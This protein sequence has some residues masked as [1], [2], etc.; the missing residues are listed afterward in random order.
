MCFDIFAIVVFSDIR[1]IKYIIHENNSFL[2][3]HSLINSK[4]INDFY[5]FYDNCKNKYD[6]C[7]NLEKIAF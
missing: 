4:F 6:Y 1:K 7:I 2:K 3:R 5:L